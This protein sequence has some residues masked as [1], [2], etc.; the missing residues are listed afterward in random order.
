MTR[1][2]MLPCIDSTLCAE[3]EDVIQFLNIIS[4]Y[5]AHMTSLA[6]T[7]SDAGY[8]AV[9]MASTSEIKRCRAIV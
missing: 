7:L 4:L 8:G 5:S 2:Y 3:V 6:L 1:F 9:S